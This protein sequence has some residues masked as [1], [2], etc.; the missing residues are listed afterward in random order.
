[1]AL[2]ISGRWEVTSSVRYAD[3]MEPN[4]T[5]DKS[6][7]T[8]PLPETDIVFNPSLMKDPIRVDVRSEYSY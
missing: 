7:Y 1:C 5:V 3:E 6:K 2:P 4:I 8:L